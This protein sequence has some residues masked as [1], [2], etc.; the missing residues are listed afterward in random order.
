MISRRIVAL[1]IVFT[2]MLAILCAAGSAPLRTNV[3]ARTFEFTYLTKI[4]A[5]PAGAK[6]L[7]I[8]I[9]LPQSDPYQGIGT[10]KI[11]SSSRCEV[12]RPR[13]RQ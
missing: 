12:S 6:T 5:S 8:W 2:F 10:L 7:L 11:E 9:P 4:P 1:C 13:I 3:S